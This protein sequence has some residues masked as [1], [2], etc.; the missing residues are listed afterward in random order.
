MRQL[1]QTTMSRRTRVGSSDN[2]YKSVW[3]ESTPTFE[4]WLTLRVRRNTWTSTL[5]N[6]KMDE[7]VRLEMDE[8]IEF[9]GPMCPFVS[10]D[11]VRC[12]FES[13]WTLSFW[14]LSYCSAR[15]L[16][17]AP[18]WKSLGSLG[19]PLNKGSHWPQ[20]SNRALHWWSMRPL[21][22]RLRSVQGSHWPQASVRAQHWWSVRALHWRLRLA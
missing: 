2:Y 15:L 18:Y 16:I 11:T 5:Y 22:W 17:Q 3:Q 4:K 21:H 12:P 20:A 1:S 19:A 7:S 10:V 14:T 8:F 6:T 13:V 9:W